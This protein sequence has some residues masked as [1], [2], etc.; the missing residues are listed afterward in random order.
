MDQSPVHT[1][2]RQSINQTSINQSVKS[3]HTSLMRVSFSS[4]RARMKRETGYRKARTKKRAREAAI[5]VRKSS[6]WKA[7]SGKRPREIW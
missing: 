4:T 3:N 2:G 1:R 6:E 5:T 7:G